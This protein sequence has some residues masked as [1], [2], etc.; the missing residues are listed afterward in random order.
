[1][2]F[3]IG[4]TVICINTG[5]MHQHPNAGNPPPLRLNHKY[6][7]QG[8]NYCSCGQMHFDIGLAT[9]SNLNTKCNCLN[10]V[11]AVGEHWANSRRFRKE[12]VIE[13]KSK[14]S[15]EEFM[16]LIND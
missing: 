10:T 11:G 9:N 5:R 3:K 13:E 2:D 1:M 12:F 6:V 8:I 15:I 7:I 4:D 16:E 14:T